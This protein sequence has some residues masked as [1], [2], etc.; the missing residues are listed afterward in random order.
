[1][2]ERF[3]D[4]VVIVTG[5]GS[6]IGA[7]TARRF[8][9]EG[10]VVALVDRN[11]R[12]VESVASELADDRTSAHVTDVSDSTAVNRMVAAVVE[13]FGRLDVMVNNA[14]VHVGGDPA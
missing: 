10:A 13:R 5:A 7:A 11:K 6:G 4:K 12:A 3:R 1:M 8:S 9:A 2:A 14:G